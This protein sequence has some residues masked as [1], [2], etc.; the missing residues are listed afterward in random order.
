[1]VSRK[2]NFGR[3]YR[4]LEIYRSGVCYTSISLFN[5]VYTNI[6]EVNQAY[7]RFIITFDVLEAIASL[8]TVSA[9]EINKWVNWLYLQQRMK[10]V[11]M[12]QQE[13]RLKETI[14]N[15]NW[16]I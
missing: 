15:Y 9:V 6:N 13:T 7:K 11:V 4:N 12:L 14:I 10:R 1:M 3:V 8:H 2:I 16:V 5:H